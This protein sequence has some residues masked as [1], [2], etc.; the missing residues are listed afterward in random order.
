VVREADIEVSEQA[1]GKMSLE[2]DL[3]WAK[4]EATR[5]GYLEKHQAHTTSIKHTL[6]LDKL[7]EE[8]KVLLQEKKHNLKV[9]EAALM[10]A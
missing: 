6:G 4:T 9:W 2:L 5:Q 1:L 3:E 10:E 7:L 8:T